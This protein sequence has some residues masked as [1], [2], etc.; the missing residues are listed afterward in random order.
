[1]TLIPNDFQKGQN[2]AF[3]ISKKEREN[4]IDKIEKLK[5]ENENL[6]NKL[7]GF[8]DNLLRYVNFCIECHKQEIPLINL[9]DYMYKLKK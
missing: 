3:E 6:K 2:L 8:E 4:L 1:M 9:E 5:Q 7:K